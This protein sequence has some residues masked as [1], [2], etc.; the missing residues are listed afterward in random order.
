MK[1]SAAQKLTERL[2][3]FAAGSAYV[4]ATATA[5]AYMASMER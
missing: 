5:A 3:K 4:S 1:G 2:T